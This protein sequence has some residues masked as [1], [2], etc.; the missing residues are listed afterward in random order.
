MQ[1]R[2]AAA[3]VCGRDVAIIE[4]AGRGKTLIADARLLL[5]ATPAHSHRCIE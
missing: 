5:H 2:G 3:S 4:Q 1:L